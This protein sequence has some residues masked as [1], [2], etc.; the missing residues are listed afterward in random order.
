MRKQAAATEELGKRIVQKIDEQGQI[1]DTILDELN[2]QERE[3]LYH[4]QNDFD[5]A[6]L[7]KNEKVVLASYLLTLISKHGQNTQSQQDY[8]FAVK[9]HL[10]V[11]EVRAD[12][13]LTLVEN[14]DSRAELKAIFRTVCEF[15]FLKDGSDSFLDTFDDELSYFCFGR[16][17]IRDT[18]QAIEDTY[19]LLGVRGI[20]EH[21]IPAAAEDEEEPVELES[22][23]W[24][25][26]ISVSRKESMEIEDMEISVGTEVSVEGELIFRRCK[27]N[28]FYGNQPAEFELSESAKLTFEECEIVC[29]NDHHSSAS[30]SYDADNDDS[31]SVVLFECCKIIGGNNFIEVDGAIQVRK[32]HIINPGWRFMKSAF[33]EDV[34]TI[35]EDTTIQFDKPISQSGFKWNDPIFVL[36]PDRAAL[37]KKCKVIFPKAGETVAN[38]PKAK[39]RTTKITKREPLS[40]EN[41]LDTGNRA[42]NEFYSPVFEEGRDGI[43]FNDCEFVNVSDVLLKSEDRIHSTFN[44]CRF[45]G[46]MDSIISKC[47]VLSFSR[48]DRKYLSMKKCTFTESE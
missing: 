18:V 2:A 42:Y 21:Y 30:I 37:V 6:D 41:M 34:A 4:L 12:F 47:R 14:V 15:L 11:T 26:P 31:K 13:D 33:L 3:T 22:E 36:Q 38:A 17:L 43:T 19:D 39:K 44:N 28:M 7:G 16:R 5:I 27:V 46:C 35:I 24:L 45:T 20:V 8:Y 25:D 40:A 32:C 29:F 9:K 23:E 48:N 10:G 1:V